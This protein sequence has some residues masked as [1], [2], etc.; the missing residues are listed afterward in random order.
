M[1]DYPF[2]SFFFVKFNDPSALW[3]LNNYKK[4]G[5]YE[6]IEELSDSIPFLELYSG[7]VMSFSVIVKKEW[8]ELFVLDTASSGKKGKKLL[9]L[10]LK[11]TDSRRSYSFNNYF[12]QFFNS[13]KNNRL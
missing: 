9:S 4:I 7:Q 2:H 11:D 8:F 1:K 3:F 6:S 13:L 10:F 12:L 5:S